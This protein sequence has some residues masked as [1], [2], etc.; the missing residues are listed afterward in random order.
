ML[1]GLHWLAN[2][3]FNVHVAGRTLWDEP[4]GG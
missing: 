4:D 3:G 1:E 2:N